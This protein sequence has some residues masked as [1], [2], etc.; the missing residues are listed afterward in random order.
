MIN[1]QIK[2]SEKDLSSI[3]TFLQGVKDGASTVLV[4]AINKTLT[5]V[6]TNVADQ[7]KAILTVNP[8]AIDRSIS[9]NEATPEK[10]S[11]SMEVTGGALPLASFSTLQTPQG[12][13]VQVK[14]DRPYTTIPGTFYAR[15]KDGRTGIFRRKWNDAASK[16][17]RNTAYGRLPYRYRLPIKELFSSSIPNVVSDVMPAILE[18]A[19]ECLQANLKD[20]LD[21]MLSKL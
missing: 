16:P 3:K 7:V 6:R 20:E 11:G 9:I 4:G 1:L 21:A 10:L 18:K 12:V 8:S 17:K 19:D 5:G 13:S 14:K 2:I 15:T